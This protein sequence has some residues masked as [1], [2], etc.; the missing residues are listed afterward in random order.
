[1]LSELSL[2]D[3]R[4]YPQKKFQFDKQ[5]VFFGKNG[6]G[7]TN[8]LEAISILSVGKSWRE[9]RGLDLILEGEESAL[10]QARLDNNNQYKIIIQPR[11][12]VF[13]KN[14]K[15]VPLKKHFGTIPSLLFAP[16]HLHLFS[17]T[18]TERQKFFD[19]F[20]AQ[21]SPQYQE[22]L[23]RA[24]SAHKNKNAVLRA[25]KDFLRGGSLIPSTIVE[26]LHPWNEI[27]AQTIPLIWKERT[28]FVQKITPLLQIELSKIADNEDPINI[29]LISAEEVE[30]SYEGIWSFFKEQTPRECAALRN[31][32]SPQR[33]DFGFFLRNKPL[34]ASASRGEERSV[35]L[36]LLSAQKK[37]L[38]EEFQITPILLLDDVFSELDEHRQAHLEH[39][40]DDVQVFFTTTHS[41]HFERFKGK[42]Q[43]IEITSPL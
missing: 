8:I 28:L 15:R 21:I 19:R 2:H 16:E 36:A 11:S 39:L 30:P 42:V 22:N 26:E 12:R 31:L 25:N 41:S 17:G 29:E 32:L 18:K 3:F 35:L 24:L 4:N 7:K 10:I 34:L 13:E 38:K 27:L 6:R 5:V 43:K 20:L 33:D 14:G 23:S 40:C 37:I 1:M 9:T